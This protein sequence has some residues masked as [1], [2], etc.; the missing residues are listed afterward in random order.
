[1]VSAV[2][3]ALSAFAFL[4]PAKPGGYDIMDKADRPALEAATMAGK[5]PLIFANDDVFALTNKGDVVSAAVFD[6]LPLPNLLHTWRGLGVKVLLGVGFDKEGSAEY[7]RR[8]CAFL[9]FR[10]GADG[11]FIRNPGELPPAW[12]AALAEA[13]TDAQ[14]IDYLRELTAAALEHDDP[15]IRM[16]GRRVEWWF[17]YM[18]ADWENLD[19]LRLECVA[20]AKHLEQLLGRPAKELPTDYKEAAEPDTVSFRPYADLASPPEQLKLEGLANKAIPLGSENFTFSSDKAGFS[21]TITCTDGPEL[22]QWRYPQGA[23]VYNISLYVPSKKAGEFSPYHLRVDLEP[24][25]VG[26]RA[27]TP[28]LSGF[29]Y[30]LEERFTPYATGYA[31]QQIRVKFRPQ[32]RTFG[33]DHQ[34]LDPRLTVTGR[35]GGG[36]TATVTVSWL[37]LYG[38]W[39]CVEN[40]KSDLWYVGID[41]LPD[42]S[43]PEPKRLLWPRGREVNYMT[44][45]K[46]INL[47]T[48]TQCYDEQLAFT[49]EVWGT[50]YRER[51][52]KF[53][54]TEKPTFHRYDLESDE[55][56]RK[57]CC[58]PLVDGNKNAWELIR[59]DKEHKGKLLAQNDTVQGLV[60]RSLDKMRYLGYNV[61]LLRRDYLRDRF[62]GKMPSEPKPEKKSPAGAAGGGDGDFID[63]GDFGG[64]QLDDMEF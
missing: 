54:T 31:R 14:V 26:P 29:L 37:S 50:A 3:A 12:K 11:V 9:P 63:A 23:G 49:D 47:G 30:S 7:F 40:G 19:C 22:A 59:T 10:Y 17:G 48:L 13:M 16:E 34:K 20:W 41:R 8:S 44:I 33:P 6:V 28:G 39:P 25:W 57:C 4:S 35:K 36:W 2:L 1:M 38:Q 21:F 46:A 62:A 42:G 27:A 51:L 53:K 56:F 32:L 55:L 52:Y 15:M 60:W 45:A 64:M 24:F 61:G 58:Q 18:E 5:A 43:R